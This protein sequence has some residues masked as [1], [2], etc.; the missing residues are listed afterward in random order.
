VAAAFVYLNH[1]I[2][3]DLAD[4]ATH[5]FLI[6]L[7]AETRPS[8]LLEHLKKFGKNKCRVPY[9]V[10]RALSICLEKSKLNAYASYN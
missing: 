9:N 3:K 4:Q 6:K 2:T 5:D 1:A 10:G 7:F 8:S